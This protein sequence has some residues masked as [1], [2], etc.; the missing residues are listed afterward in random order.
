MQAGA[1]RIVESDL[2][3]A[4]DEE[5]AVD[6]SPMIYA[7]DGKGGKKDIFVQWSSSVGDQR[8][9][10]L[11]LTMKRLTSMCHL[12]AYH[13]QAV[14]I[15]QLKNIPEGKLLRRRLEKHYDCKHDDW[16]M[17]AVAPFSSKRKE[18]GRFLPAHFVSK[19]IP[20]ILS[21]RIVEPVHYRDDNAW[22]LAEK[23]VNPLKRNFSR[24]KVDISKN[25]GILL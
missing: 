12:D 22:I 13:F 4:G 6:C 3:G 19:I 17:L 10:K 18:D 15:G 21:D 14:F 5:V 16:V 7:K 8:E 20:L 24:R 11:S 25:K 9:F 1:L 2:T 23:R